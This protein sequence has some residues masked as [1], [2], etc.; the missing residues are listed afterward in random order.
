MDRKSTSRKS[1]V[2][3]DHTTVFLLG[4]AWSHGRGRV[5]EIEY[6]SDSQQWNKCKMYKVRIGGGSCLWFINSWAT[7]STS[8]G[9][10]HVPE[11]LDLSQSFG[12]DCPRNLARLSTRTG[13]EGPRMAVDKQTN[14]V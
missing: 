8:L 5:S 4:S 7:N 14:L 12:Q 9:E 3:S 13:A 6:G 11:D 1:S 2:S 10:P